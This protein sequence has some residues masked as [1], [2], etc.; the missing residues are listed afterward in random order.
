M[1]SAQIP[2][3]MRRGLIPK[4]KHCVCPG[5]RGRN[6]FTQGAG[7]KDTAIT[8]PNRAIDHQQGCRFVQ[9]WILESIV[10]D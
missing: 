8:K 7:W 9:A 5:Q 1:E 10:H 4:N 2:F 6:R 3:Q